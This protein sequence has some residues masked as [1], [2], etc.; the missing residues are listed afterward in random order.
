MDGTAW[1]VEYSDTNPNEV[2]SETPADPDT[3]LESDA[4]YG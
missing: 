1:I 4:L 3:P 2:L